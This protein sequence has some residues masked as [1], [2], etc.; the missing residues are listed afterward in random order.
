[1]CSRIN[2]GNE[3]V[4]KRSASA[5][6]STRFPLTAGIPP[7]RSTNAATL[8]KS[9]QGPGE[10]RECIRQSALFPPEELSEAARVSRLYTLM[11]DWH[12]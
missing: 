1:M 9:G 3:P 8:Q 11:D 6:S 7:N 2:I 4:D 10:R 5:I 12:R